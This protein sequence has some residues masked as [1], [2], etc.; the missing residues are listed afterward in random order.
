LGCCAMGKNCFSM[1]QN[2]NGI[3]L[4]YTDKTRLYVQLTFTLEMER[5]YSFEE[6]VLSHKSFDVA[7]QSKFIA[8]SIQYYCNR[9]NSHREKSLKYYVNPY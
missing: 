2:K 1:E 6:L 4:Q 7:N 8:R 9:M 3:S 5:A